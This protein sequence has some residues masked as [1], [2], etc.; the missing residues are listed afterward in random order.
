MDK[1]DTIK[2]NNMTLQT[3]AH[4]KELGAEKFQELFI[5]K[6]KI[7]KIDYE[8]ELKKYE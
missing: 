4:K 7:V 6:N 2:K 8:N 3:S 1:M 5:L